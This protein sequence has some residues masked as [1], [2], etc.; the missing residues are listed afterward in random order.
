LK[1]TSRSRHH[2]VLITLSLSVSY[3]EIAPATSS[4]CKIT[5][6]WVE[7]SWSP[8]HQAPKLWLSFS[9]LL[10]L[11]FMH[12]YDPA[13]AFINSKKFRG[14]GQQLDLLTIWTSCGTIPM[15]KDWSQWRKSTLLFSVKL[16]FSLFFYP[17]RN[18]KSEASLNATIRLSLLPHAF[19]FPF[20]RP[21]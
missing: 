16:N 14:N 17:F 13:F 7:D 5:R 19:I 6:S 15:T 8:R 3:V 1:L 20:T 11:F 4:N 12:L 2:L 18:S 9:L 21:P 10:L